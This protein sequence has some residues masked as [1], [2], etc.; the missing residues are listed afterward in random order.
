MRDMS[1]GYTGK[2]I[3]V[4][5]STGNIKEEA[6]DDTFYRRYIGGW[7]I[8]SYY[9]LN[10]L[11]PMVA[12][13]GP[14]NKLIFAA[15]PIT[16]VPLPGNGRNA[17]GAKSPLTGGFGVGEAGGYWGAELKHAGFDGIII[18]GRSE[19]PVYLWLKDGEAELRD[20]KHLWGK[21]TKETQE[22]IRKELDD[23]RIRVASIGPGGENKVLYSCII[24]DLTNAIGRSGLGAVMGSKNLKSIAVRGAETTKVANPEKIKELT[25]TLA[26]NLKDK[27]TYSNLSRE[28]ESPTVQKTKHERTTIL[29]SK[30][31]PPH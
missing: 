19:N 16:G 3:R 17:V 31:Q 14:E 30:R 12:P 9:M 13:L 2:I 7:G 10:E 20:G 25:A 8:I 23:D 1:K 15:G 18:E 4:D 26:E 5:L 6:H 22:T 29:H 24:N 11:K 28:P 21:F 27:G